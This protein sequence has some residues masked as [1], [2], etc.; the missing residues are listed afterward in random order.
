MLR[1]TDILLDIK[2]NAPSSVNFSITCS[3]DETCKK[4]EPFVSTTTKRFEAIEQ[5]AKNGVAAGVLMDPIIPYITDTEENVREMVK[6]A[7][8]YGAKY[9][10]FNACNHG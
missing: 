10:Y 7:K 5:L 4:I 3:D 1:D 2:K 9:I 6:K 8:H